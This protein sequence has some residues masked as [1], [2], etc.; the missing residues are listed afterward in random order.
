MLLECA[1][2]CVRAM[3]VLV[4]DLARYLNLPYQPVEYD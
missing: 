1:D 2:G 4:F 3:V